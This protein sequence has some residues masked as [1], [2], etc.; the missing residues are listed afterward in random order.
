MWLDLYHY[1]AANLSLFWQGEEIIS[2]DD[3]HWELIICM[4]LFLNKN[5]LL[6]MTG[7]SS[8]GGSI[9][10]VLLFIQVLTSMGALPDHP[11]VSGVTIFMTNMDFNMLLLFLT[12]HSHD[13]SIRCLL[14][15]SSQQSRI[16]KT[17]I[18]LTGFSLVM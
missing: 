6:I 12:L 8:C 10:T 16:D 5:T 15:R 11:S 14:G 1:T 18:L 7:I 13:F 3:Q 4:P 17:Y 2:L 9:I